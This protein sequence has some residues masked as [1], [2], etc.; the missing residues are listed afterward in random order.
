MF[1]PKL[2]DSWT[3]GIF[4]AIVATGRPGKPLFLY[5]DSEILGEISNLSPV[6]AQKAFAKS[7]LKHYSK[8]E[9]DTPF[10]NA[11][12]EAL[13]WPKTPGFKKSSCPQIIPLLALCVIAV[14]DKSPS[15]GQSVYYLL[16]SLLGQEVE[17]G[18]PNGYEFMPEIWE[19]W[20]KWLKNSGAKYGKSTARVIDHYALQGYARSQG[21]IRRRE[22]IFIT[23]FFSDSGILP[24]TELQ[25]EY[26]ISLFETWLRGQGKREFALYEKIFESG[27][28]TTRVI[29]S[30][31]LANEL[32]NWDGLTQTEAGGDSLVGYLAKDSFGTNWE[33][34]CGVQKKVIGIP[35]DLGDGP[36][37]VDESWP[38]IYVTQIDPRKIGEIL[39]KGT[40]YKLNEKLSLKAGGRNYYLFVN[41]KFT[42]SGFVEERNP[43]LFTKYKLLVE[44]SLIVQMRESLDAYEATYTEPELQQ[45]IGYYEISELVFAKRRIATDSK[46]KFKF[47]I[48]PPP[49]ITLVGGLQIGK[50]QY[51]SNY[52]PKVQL[53]FDNNFVLKI[54]GN[55]IDFAHDQDYIDLGK[56]KLKLGSHEIQFGDSSIVFFLVESKKIKPSSSSKGIAL[57]NISGAIKI[58]SLKR[59]RVS[60]KYRIR[61]ALFPENSIPVQDGFIKF[62]YEYSNVFLLQDDEILLR[63]IN[64]QTGTRFPGSNWRY[65][66]NIAESRLELTLLEN[67]FSG[68]GYLI[69]KDATSRKCTL[70]RVHGR[71][72]P[73]NPSPRYIPISSNKAIESILLSEWVFLDADFR[74]QESVLKTKLQ[75]IRLTAPMTPM[76]SSSELFKKFKS[77]D[78]ARVEYG[79]LDFLLE[80]ISEQ[81]DSTVSFEEFEAAWDTLE[82]T[83]YHRNWRET[84]N[85]LEQLGHLEVDDAIKKICAHPAVVNIIQGEGDYGILVGARPFRMQEILA[86]NAPELIENAIEFENHIHYQLRYQPKDFRDLGNPTMGPAV[87]L[88]RTSDF[89]GENSRKLLMDLGIETSFNVGKRTLIHCPTVSEVAYIGQEYDLSL[90]N[91]FEQFSGFRETPEGFR[92][93]W[94]LAKSD[95]EAGIYRYIRDNSNKILAVRFRIGEQLHEIDRQWARYIYFAHFELFPKSTN[96]GRNSTQ[97]PSILEV[98]ED[99]LFFVPNIIRLPKIVSQ[100]LILQTGLPPES[101]EGGTLYQNVGRG[102]SAEIARILEFERIEKTGRHMILEKGF[103]RDLNL[104][105]GISL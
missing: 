83:G 101:Y 55:Q 48:D 62:P 40:T 81:E 90:S 50:N 63:Q 10:E 69:F 70:L 67:A 87:A 19:I 51:E 85:Y 24:G 35:I 98:P 23:D 71:K 58:G 65:I 20:N 103:S 49:K 37:V 93:V 27:E 94:T 73:E 61:G 7:F 29:F 76:I 12:L 43:K 57:K 105:Y 53:P 60:D 39:K 32:E 2:L 21:F 18:K 9:C 47:P 78:V 42:Y 91:R 88:I 16:N 41:G 102:D 5:L 89:F 34:I 13:N 72:D 95:K 11:V 66:L 104:R 26:L 79:P 96:S 30:E 15:P 84:A 33:V 100:G 25:Q 4:K 82:V 97:F 6:D 59:T 75:K 28:L 8:G 36:K 86:G 99:K 22:R 80:W 3:E 14:T 54:D 77:I 56:F 74:V 44:S 46:V 45:D 17:I 38:L 64:V 52:P 92:E 31:I 68:D 1:D